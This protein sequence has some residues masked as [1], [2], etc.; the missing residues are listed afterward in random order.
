MPSSVSINDASDRQLS[1]LLGLD[2]RQINIVRDL[3]PVAT[4]AQLVGRLPDSVLARIDDALNVTKR[5]LNGARVGELVDIAGI[6]L[7]TAESIVAKRPYYVALELRAVPGVDAGTFAMV[8]AYFAP[9]PLAYVDKLSGQSVDLTPDT[10][11]LLVSLRQ[12]DE[13]SATLFGGRH[14]LRRLSTSGD[15]HGYQVL[16]VPQSEGHTDAISELKDDALV[17]SVVP[18]F[19]RRSGGS[20]FIDPQFCVAQFRADVGEGRQEEVMA[21]SRMVLEERHRTPGLVTLRLLIRDVNPAA[22]MRAIRVLNAA[23]EV[24]FAEPAFIGVND[25]EAAD[26]G[27]ESDAAP[28]IDGVSALPWNLELVGVQPAVPP[29]PGSD[30]VVVAVIDTGVDVSHPALSAAILE[31]P[32]GDSWNFED[33]GDPDPVD[34]EGH[35]TFIA[36]LLAGRGHNDIWGICPGCSLLPLKIPLAGTS[37]SYAKRRDAILYAIGLVREPRR[38]VINLSW[39]TTGDVALVRDAIS[40]AEQA[41]AVV[42]ASAGNWPE[43]EDEPH[44][45]SDYAQVVSVGAVGPDRRRALYSFFGK[46]V[47]LV[48]PGGS[49]AQDPAG[50]LHSARPNGA[51]G[52]DFGT[53]FSGPHVAGAAALLLSRR[54]DL[55]VTDLRRALERSAVPVVD[56]GTGHGLL[57]IPAGMSMISE[58]EPASAGASEDGLTAVNAMDMPSLL[59][60]FGLLAIT[61]RMIIARR[62]IATL[63]SLSGLLGLTD[64]QRGRIAAYRGQ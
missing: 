48:A 56:S 34:S 64:E 39:K 25:L 54:R 18:A 5:D 35:G 51:Y 46:E 4:R 22:I 55:S 27:F 8:T 58:T 33:D 42:V 44:F 12:T 38:L 21:D 45:P 61:A 47:D 36:G 3:R 16:L 9:Q 60:A 49:G 17:E 23:S 20:V 40:Q 24:E 37:L 11:R 6:D 30:Q 53:S 15:A 43:T 62:P 13:E 31:R 2:Q 50:N 57:N 52:V 32:P 14:K 63:E 26:T 29:G 59:R 7:L 10:S 19:R 28:P 1:V 41:G